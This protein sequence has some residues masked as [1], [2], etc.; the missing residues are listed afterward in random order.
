[1]SKSM[2]DPIIRSLVSVPEKHHGLLLDT[3]NK[4][5][6]EDADDV[7]KR[8]AKALREPRTPPTPEPPLDTIVR[9]DRSV[10]PVYPD[11]VKTVMHPEL[12]KV[13]P[14]EYDLATVD[15]WLHD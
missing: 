7:H 8:L 14:A 4:L 15:L 2:L 1:M 12:E 10:R 11:F 9:V 6:G 13:G 3:I 5:G